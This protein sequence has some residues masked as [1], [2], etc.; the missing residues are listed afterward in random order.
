MEK[1]SNLHVFPTLI[2]YTEDFLTLDECNKLLKLKDSSEF[3]KHLSIVGDGES[4]HTFQDSILNKT[5]NWLLNILTNKINSYALDYGVREVKLD[6]SW[7]SIQ[8]EGSKLN[9]HT[10]PD[11]IISGAL[12][13]KT[14]SGSSKIYFH[15]PVT[16]TT[17]V[18][19]NKQTDFSSETYH[20]TPKPGDLLLFP[21]WLGHGSNNNKN[22]SNERIVLSFNTKYL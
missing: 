19:Y 7:L 1:R 22:K 2:N 10:H 16:F 13:L 20:F 4:T 14:D 18:S 8:K 6:N 12:Y 17:F 15:N 5:Y 11:S 21:S 9:R 3:K